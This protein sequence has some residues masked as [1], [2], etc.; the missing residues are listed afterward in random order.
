MVFGSLPS[1]LQRRECAVLTFTLTSATNEPVRHV[2]SCDPNRSNEVIRN[3]RLDSG[4]VKN[5]FPSK[6]TSSCDNNT[7]IGGSTC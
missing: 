2:P 6:F 7:K 3:E 4:R 5:M 1:L